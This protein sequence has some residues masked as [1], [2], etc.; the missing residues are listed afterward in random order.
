MWWVSMFSA[1]EEWVDGLDCPI[2][3]KL[4]QRINQS[5]SGPCASLL[6]FILY[7]R[8]FRVS[9]RAAFRSQLPRMVRVKQ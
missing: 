7:K 1:R 3:H 5:R 9:C 6:I 8:I 2:S 4:L